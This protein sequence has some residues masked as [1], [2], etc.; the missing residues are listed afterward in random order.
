M[1]V[2]KLPQQKQRIKISTIEMS[3]ETKRNKEQ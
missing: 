1:V 3:S 2:P